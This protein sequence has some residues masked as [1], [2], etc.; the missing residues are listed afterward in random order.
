MAMRVQSPT[1]PMKPSRNTG[2]RAHTG[3]SFASAPY[4]CSDEE[5]ADEAEVLSALA[6]GEEPKRPEK[7]SPIELRGREVFLGVGGC[8]SAADDDADEEAEEEDAG[9]SDADDL[10]APAPIPFFTERCVLR[11]RSD[12][13]TKGMQNR[14][15]RQI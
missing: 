6:D 3:S 9:S 5:E 15:L 13:R 14:N 11:S 4:G 8:A 2:K 1:L 10:P 7:N 12:E